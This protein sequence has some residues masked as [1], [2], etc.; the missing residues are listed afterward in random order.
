MLLLPSKKFS[1]ILLA[2]FFIFDAFSSYYAV[3]YMGG[4]EGNPFIASY[5]QNNPKLF[6]PIMI[7]GYILAYLIYSILK[8]MLWNFLKRF[9][10][11]TQTLVEQIVIVAIA[12]FYFFTVILNNS[13]YLIGFRVPG[14]L[15]VNLIIGLVAAPIYGLF[16]L[17]MSSKNKVI[18]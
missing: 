6:F 15:R 2:L 12:I 3:S 8:I 14:T 4:K 17:Y 1:W 16:V 5:V 7:F 10:F 13:L 11:V 9:K 18:T